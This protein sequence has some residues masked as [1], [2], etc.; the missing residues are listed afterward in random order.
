MTA[1][2]PPKT[3]SIELVPF[4]NDLGKNSGTFPIPCSS[5]EVSFVLLPS[6]RSVLLVAT[7][8]LCVL[9]M[10][11]EMTPRCEKAVS[12]AVEPITCQVVLNAFNSADPVAWAVTKAS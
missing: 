12:D 8:S 1:L 3:Y 6:N 9:K 7:N 5:S 2:V 4:E 11:L 10:E